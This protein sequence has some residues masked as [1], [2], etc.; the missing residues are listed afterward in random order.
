MEGRVFTQDTM[1]YITMFEG[2]TNV[3]V[4]DCL[5]FD[6]RLVFIVERGRLAKAIGRG[7]RNLARMRS[8]VKKRIQVVEWDPDKEQFIR[9]VFNEYGVKRVVFEKRG[10]VNHATIFVDPEK[11]ASSIGK[12]GENLRISREII[13][14]YFD[15]QSINIG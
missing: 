2:I 14:S 4:R 15:V 12:N 5:E 3:H 1:R 13:A 6:S 8:I 10:H 7:G 11:K 9:R